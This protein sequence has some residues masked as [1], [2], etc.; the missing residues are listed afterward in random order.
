M[1][2]SVPSFPTCCFWPSKKSFSAHNFSFIFSSCW[3]HRS[4]SGHRLGQVLRAVS[5]DNGPGWVL[6]YL[7][8]L[9]RISGI[10]V[11]CLGVVMEANMYNK[12]GGRDLKFCCK[13]TIGSATGEGWWSLGSPK[14]CRTKDASSLSFG[15]VYEL[16]SHWWSMG[17]P[18]R[19]W[20]RQ[21]TRADA[22]TEHTQPG[23]IVNK[24]AT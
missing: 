23:T 20:A 24:R 13:N 12:W 15:I 2:K 19:T 10:T 21:L 3:R 8:L 17:D 9:L 22:G 4:L 18:W 14:Y 5:K 1:P 7:S 6:A 16:C 11:R